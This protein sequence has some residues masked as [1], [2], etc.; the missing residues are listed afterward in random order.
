MGHVWGRQIRSARN[1]L[2]SLMKTHGTSLDEKPLNSLF[3]EV[4]GSVNSRP[5][6]VETINYRNSQAALSPSHM[7]QHISNEFWSC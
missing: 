1:I 3:V 7:V 4:E 5:L 6:V 2:S